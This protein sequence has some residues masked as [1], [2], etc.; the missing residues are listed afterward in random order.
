MKPEQGGST[1]ERRNSFA[2]GAL[3]FLAVAYTMH[4][5]ADLLVPIFFSVLMAVLFFPLVRRFKRLGIPPAL[6]A[7]VLIVAMVAGAWFALSFLAEPAEQWLQDAP[8]SI[9]QLREDSLQA[10]QKMAEIKALADEVD[11]LTEMQ[12]ETPEAD[13]SKPQAVTIKGPGIFEEFVGSLPTL[14]AQTVIVLFLTFFLLIT[15]DDFLLKLVRLGRN[16]TERR[17]IVTIARGIQSELSRYLRMVTV[18]NIALGTATGLF[19]HWV[20]VPDAMMWGSL[21]AVFN[22]APYI[23]AMTSTLLLT[24]VGLT[25]F[26]TPGEALLVPAGFLVLTTL[27]GQVITPTVVGRNLRISPTVVLLSV[28][29][30]GWFWGIA[31]A[32]MAVPLLTCFK[33]FCDH[34]PPMQFVGDFLGNTSRRQ[35]PASS[36]ADAPREAGPKAQ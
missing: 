25:T 30:W 15:A 6:T 2:L 36:G 13:R 23:G 33:V 17:K 10:D 4:L 22:F 12:D 28:I 21:V 14:A 5:A 18:I 26:P 9:R 24:V 8:R 35:G 29:L 16:W 11:E 19:L 3:L 31:G 32:L 20:G 7:G 27:E 34:Y 1:R